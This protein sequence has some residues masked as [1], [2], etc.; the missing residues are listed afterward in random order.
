MN[1][2]QKSILVVDDS[3][4]FL[5]YISMTLRRMGYDKIIPA[6]NGVDALELV[7]LLLPDVVLLDVDMPQM[8]GITTLRQIKENKNISKIPVIMISSTDDAEKVEACKRLGCLGYLMKPI[9]ITELNETLVQCISYAGGQKRK[10]LRTTFDKK[11][12][13]THGRIKKDHHA[14]SLSEGGIFIRKINPFPV[15]TEVEVTLQLKED[16]TLTMRGKVIYVKCISG[17]FFK[18]VPGMAIE[19]KDV[20]SENSKMLKEYIVE[21]LTRDIIEIQEEPVIAK[22]R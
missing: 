16:K 17:D 21:L 8:D 11:V 20:S 13:V 15:G 6:N 14:V 4:I 3:E 10:L 22:E 7:A 2:R 18:I 12:T 9:K 19:F 1:D 5:T